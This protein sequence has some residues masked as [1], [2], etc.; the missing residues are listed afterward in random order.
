MTGNSL[1]G[2]RALLRALRCGSRSSSSCPVLAPASCYL[3]VITCVPSCHAVVQLF[4]LKLVISWKFGCK[5]VT[6]F[7]VVLVVTD[8]KRSEIIVG[9]RVNYLCGG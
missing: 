8:L 3:C 7:V 9:M 1:W 6:M 4:V 5:I 2:V